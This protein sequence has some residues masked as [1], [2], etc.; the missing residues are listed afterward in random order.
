MQM[1]QNTS[2]YITDV[3]YT[4]N[5]YEHL[6][7]LTLNYLAALNGHAPRDL[8]NFDYCELGCGAGLSLLIHAA[9]FPGGRFV[10]I[11]LNPEHIEQA[12]RRASAAGL[13]NLKLLAEPVSHKLDR[14][15]L[16]SFDFIVLHGLYAWVSDEVRASILHFIDARLKPGGQVLLS[17]NAMPGCAAR[18]PLRD[19]MRRFALPLS[20]NSIERAHLGLS[21]LRLMLNAQ[22]PFFRLNPELARYAESLFERDPQ[23]IA[24][25]F[26]NEH[27]QPLGIDQVA[28]ELGEAGLQF[29]GTLPLWQNH[30][31]AD[32]P[33]NLA[34]LFS[35]QTSRIAREVHKDFIYNTVFRID[36]FIRPEAADSAPCGR[37]VALWSTPFCTVTPPEKVELSIQSGSLKLPLNTRESRILFGL[38]HLQ[39]RT[40]AELSQHPS[41]KA[42]SP[43]AIVDTICWWVLSGQVRPALAAPPAGSLSAS[44]C[45]LNNVVLEAA[46]HSPAQEKA[47]LASPRFGVGFAFEKTEALVL[48][49]LAGSPGTDP[50]TALFAQIQQSGLSVEEEGTPMNEADI[51]QLS[52]QIYDELD[53]S[54]KLERARQLA[55]IE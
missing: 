35:A 28:G 2:G 17:Y 26:F 39:P 53:A 22:V 48:C 5:Y 33:E 54:G 49:A 29:A 6:S 34:G 38:L 1:V 30:P 4:D 7:P 14:S 8:T 24:H 47:W 3:A 15:D 40:P 45:R 55:I 44:T 23:Y 37:A 42:M 10:G 43:E 36:L 18:Q 20:Q 12:R 51:R 16:P 41:L 25:E 31:E 11:D 9:C 13:D 46:L 32:V 21:Y 50:S 19:I 27:W 52:D